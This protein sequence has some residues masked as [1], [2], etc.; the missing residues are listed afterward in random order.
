MMKFYQMETDFRT[1]NCGLCNV[2]ILEDG[3]FIIEDGGHFTDGQA[4][5]LHDFLSAHSKGTIRV[6]A[7]LF[8]HAHA[9]HIGAFIMVPLVCQRKYMNVQARVALWPAARY[10]MAKNEKYSA[11]RYLLY[12]SGMKHILSNDGTAEFSLPDEKLDFSVL[13]R[14]FPDKSI[15]S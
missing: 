10:E 7:W 1:V 13:P 8:S 5:A 12:E 9:D 15:P 14:V 11:N 3:S 4:E 6:A 2:F